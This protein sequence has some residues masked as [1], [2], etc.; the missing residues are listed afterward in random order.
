[1]NQN[2]P[3]EESIRISTRTYPY[4]SPLEQEIVSE[5]NN[6]SYT[7]DVSEITQTI[8]ERLIQKNKC[9]VISPE[10]FKEAKEALPT[11]NGDLILDNLKNK[12]LEEFSKRKFLECTVNA[13]TEQNGDIAKNFNKWFQDFKVIGVPSGMGTVVKASYPDHHFPKD[14]FVFK[15]PQDTEDL[16]D[17]YNEA[18]VSIQ[19]INLLKEK[20]PNFPYT[21]GYLYCSDINYQN[22]T[23]SL[24]TKDGTVPYLIMENVGPNVTLRNMVEQQ[25]T[26]SDQEVVNIM[27]QVLNALA[28]AQENIGFTHYDLHWENILISTMKNS[29]YIPWCLDNPNQNK[30]YLQTTSLLATI[31]DFGFSSFD[32]NGT[33]LGRSDPF[34]Q[35]N[36][37]TRHSSALSDI[38]KIFGYID[39]AAKRRP[40]IRETLKRTMDAFYKDFLSLCV[41]NRVDPGDTRAYTFSVQNDYALYQK[42]PFRASENVVAAERA[43]IDIGV[44]TPYYITKKIFSILQKELPL[45]SK[46]IVP[47]ERVNKELIYNYDNKV[48]TAKQSKGLFTSEKQNYKNS[49]DVAEH[50][51][52]LKQTYKENPKGFTEAVAEINFQMEP[53][54]EYIEKRISEVDAGMKIVR[55]GI[56]PFLTKYKRFIQ[57]NKPILQHNATELFSTMGELYN[58]TFPVKSLME[59]INSISNA[60]D[61]VAGIYTYLLRKTKIT[62]SRIRGLV[63][64]QRNTL[65]VYKNE[66]R[67]LYALFQ[68]EMETLLSIGHMNPEFKKFNS[69]FDNFRNNTLDLVGIN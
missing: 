32:Y 45:V 5:I 10:S 36:L 65:P 43:L 61:Q 53:E 46:F 12:D 33:Q 34:A 8:E 27:L 55:E 66:I 54:V 21:Y 51:E 4:I 15:I 40:I 37:I 38:Q 69:V 16:I 23:V 24:C 42:V 60:I 3:K 59:L 17:F 20:I 2:A 58:A 6:A 11:L 67:Q 39:H 62:R 29:M 44:I 56:M 25:T 47:R 18:A 49:K 28:F 52:R 9:S 50:I 14:I 1:M 63:E 57:N 22:G 7:K 35:S 26:Y 64:Y 13:A 30:S 41:E 68:E 31:I 19:G 48:L